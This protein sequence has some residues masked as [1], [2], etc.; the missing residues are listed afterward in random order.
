MATYGKKL[1]DS[2]NNVILPKTRSNLVYMNNNETVEKTINDILKRLGLIED[3]TILTNAN[4]IVNEAI[5]VSG[6][7]GDGSFMVATDASTTNNKN[8]SRAY[9]NALYAKC[10][11]DGNEISTKYMP[12][13]GGAFTGSASAVNTNRSGA[14][15]RNIEVKNSSSAF[16][17]TNLIIFYRQ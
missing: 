15:L 9:Y 10:D 12:K 13:S 7:N 14:T 8:S 1:L 17:S 6:E 16:V 3:G 5:L 4:Q 2:N 11:Y